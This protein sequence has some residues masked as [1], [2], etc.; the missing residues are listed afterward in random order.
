L[1]DSIDRNIKKKQSTLE[2]IPL[3]GFKTQNDMEIKF[4]LKKVSFQNEENL[5][6]NHDMTSF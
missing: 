6:K 1:K 4:K 3:K 2:G 5:E